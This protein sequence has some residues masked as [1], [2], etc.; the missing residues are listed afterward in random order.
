MS[1][2]FKAAIRRPSALYGP[3]PPPTDFSAWSLLLA[4]VV[5]LVLA[6]ALDW[7]LGD[8]LIVYWFQ[9]VVIGCSYVLRILNLDKFCTENFTINGKSVKPTGATKVKVA[10]FFCMHFGFFHLFYLLFIFSGEITGTQ[11]LVTLPMVVACLAFAVNHAYSYNYFKDKDR[12]GKPNIGTMMFTPYLRIVPMHLTI[13]LGGAIG[14][15]GFG[16]LLFMALKTV[17]D[18][19]MHWTEHRVIHNTNA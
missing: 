13:I 2:P 8:L 7:Q 12:E 18:I 3:P 5:A 19:L 4:N 14:V 10:G 15:S 9:S 17:T 1:R 11:V 6:L 16:L